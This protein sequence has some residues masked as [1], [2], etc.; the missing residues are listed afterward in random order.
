MAELMPEVL[1]D[2]KGEEVVEVGVLKRWNLSLST[3]FKEEG[4]GDGW[5]KNRLMK[6]G[7]E[8][9]DLGELDPIWRGNF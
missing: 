2:E 8:I 4:V 6:V 3:Y 1:Q 9:S 7:V 5:K